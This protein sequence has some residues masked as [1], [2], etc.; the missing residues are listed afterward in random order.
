MLQKTMEQKRS[1][2]KVFA[3]FS[4]DLFKL[5]SFQIAFPLKTTRLMDVCLLCFFIQSCPFWNLQSKTYCYMGKQLRFLLFPHFKVVGSL[6]LT[7]NFLFFCSFSA[8]L[9]E[10]PSFWPPHCHENSSKESPWKVLFCSSWTLP[11]WEC[12]GLTL[13]GMDFASGSV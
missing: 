7:I 3:T 5:P 4:V 1:L 12:P 10:P 2:E 6:T 13:P 8:C 11:R 9:A